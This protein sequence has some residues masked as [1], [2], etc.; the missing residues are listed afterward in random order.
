MGDGDVRRALGRHRDP[1]RLAGRVGGPGVYAMWNDLLYGDLALYR[2]TKTGV[3][4]DPGGDADPGA[5]GL[6]DPGPDSRGAEESPQPI[7]ERA[8]V[9]ADR[10]FL[11]AVPAW[12]Q[13]AEYPPE[14]VLD[15]IDH[16]AVQRIAARMI[17]GMISAPL[18]SMLV[19]PAAYYL[20]RK[21]KR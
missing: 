6:P 4:R 19:I 18:L 12:P 13:L 2:T 7:A 5:D 16:G 15:A 11:D 10:R 20:M 1:R 14:K 17:G 8:A 21:S 9:R 3:F